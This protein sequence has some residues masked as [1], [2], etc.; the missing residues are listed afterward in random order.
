LNNISNSDAVSKWNSSTQ[1]SQGLVYIPAWGI[2]VGTNFNLNMEEGYEV[3]VN[4]T[5]YWNQI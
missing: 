3:S 5:T 2:Y 4:Q 1:T